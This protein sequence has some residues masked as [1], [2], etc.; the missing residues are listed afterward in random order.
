MKIFKKYQ[1][2]CPLFWE[3]KL[4][5]KEWQVEPAPTRSDLDWKNLAYDSNHRCIRKISIGMFLLIGS[6]VV[7]SPITFLEG[8]LPKVVTNGNIFENESNFFS[9]FAVYTCPLLLYFL[10]Y[11]FLPYIILKTNFYENNHRFSMREFSIMNK[12]YIYMVFNS[13]MM[14]GLT[15]TITLR[16]V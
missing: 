2:T 14:P 10:N 12:L 15:Y 7:V 11:M 9:F 5:I 1:K 3:K 6:L 13:I 8:Y 4:R 16:L